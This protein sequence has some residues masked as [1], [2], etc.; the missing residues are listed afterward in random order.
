MLGL[1]FSIPFSLYLASCKGHALCVSLNINWFL[2]ALMKSVCHLRLSL[3][4]GANL[5]SR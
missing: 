4:D 5:E 2:V 3:L 1:A